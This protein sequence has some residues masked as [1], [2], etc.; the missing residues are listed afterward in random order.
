MKPLRAKLLLL[1]GGAALAFAIP[2]MGQ[3]E[4]GPESLL[5]PGFGDPPPPAP[6]E[7]APETP[8]APSPSPPA[9]PQSAPAPPRSGAPLEIEDAAAEDLEAL[10]RQSLPPPIEIPEGS[11]RP[12]NPVGPLRPGN[13]G[14]GL[15]AFGNANGRFL[16]G[17][18]GRL[19]A[20]L[21]SRWTSILLRRALLSEATAPKQVNEVDWVAER[22]WLLLRMGEADSARMLVQAVDVDRFTP[23]MFSVAVQTAL[24]TADPAAL[25]PLVG[26]G[27]KVSDQPVWPLA[28]AMCASLEGDAARASQLI[29]QARRRSGGGIDT[30]LAEKVIGAGTNTRRAVTIEWQGVS[31]LNSW[32]FGLASATGLEIPSELLSRAGPAVWAWQARA[33]MIPLEQRV[34][35]AQR[36]A[37]LGVFS[38]SSLVE[39]HSLLADRTDPSEIEASLGGRLRRAYV[40]RSVGDRMDALRNLWEEGDD[41]YG[42]FILTAAAAAGIPVSAD[43]GNRTDDLVASMMSGGYDRFAARWGGVADSLDGDDG[44]RA[45]SIL[46]VGAPRPVVDL[47]ASRIEAFTDGV[48]GHR[49]RMLVAALAGLG[50]LDDPLPYGVATAPRSRWA[51]LIAAAGRANQPGTV[52]LLAGVGMQTPS[53]RGV[54][55]EHL[56]HIVHALTQV[57]LDYEARM[58]AA[59]AMTRL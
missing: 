53:W 3:R 9:A 35:A 34:A 41:P 19:N 27:R 40:A 33:P 14:L 22:A 4:K 49:G 56:Y 15:D 37:V 52:A 47:G 30:L 48:D 26:P 21:P 55:P 6:K 36:A 57:G 28:D 25:C 39:L 58:I 13:W 1:A 54:P 44:Q 50:R 8:A 17:L 59:E 46:A 12:V 29:E 11:R 31:E 10:A 18:M 20:P 5:P 16:S 2:A 51:N 43:R 38:N 7:P 24:A 42:R 32:R 23:R 45:W